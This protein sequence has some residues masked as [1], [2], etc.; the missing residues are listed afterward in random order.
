M[1]GYSQ[2]SILARKALMSHNNFKRSNTQVE[3]ID[4]AAYLKLF[5]NTIAC[6]EADGTLKITNCRWATVTTKCRLNALPH[7]SIYQKDWV[8][9]LNDRAWN[10]EWTIV[11]NPDPTG[12]EWG[13]RF[14]LGVAIEDS[15]L[16]DKTDDSVEEMVL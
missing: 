6:H 9:Y 7:V 11:Y 10:G 3:V 13:R 4:G 5:G 15:P 8:W 12:D 2:I 14:T 1:S 16:T